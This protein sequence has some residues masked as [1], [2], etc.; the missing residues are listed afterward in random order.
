MRSY[1]D[2]K[3]SSP[4]DKKH[5]ESGRVKI[6]DILNMPIIV[7]DFESGLQ[8]AHSENAFVIDFEMNGIRQ[9]FF[10]TSPYICSDLAALDKSDFPFQTVIKSVTCGSNKITYKFT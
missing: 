1:N 10:T 4:G 5:F 9:K 3:R 2:I 7:H 6:T 8:T